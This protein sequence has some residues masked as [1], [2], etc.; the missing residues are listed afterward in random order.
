MIRCDLWV[1]ISYLPAIQLEISTTTTKK[2]NLINWFKEFVL[3]VNIFNNSLNNQIR[4][5]HNT[6]QIRWAIQSLQNAFN[7]FIL[8]IA[9]IFEL[10]FRNAVQTIFNASLGSF[11]QLIVHFNDGHIIAGCCRNLNRNVC[12]LFW[13]NDCKNWTMNSV[14]TMTWHNHIIGCC[15]PLQK[16]HREIAK[17]Q[18]RKNTILNLLEQF[19]NP[20]NRHQ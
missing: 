5:F 19:Q 4:L 10:L 18:N 8:L 20:S 3:D 2:I 6:S 9:I 17:L 13:S 12:D 14:L 15:E 16:S 11:N 1:T 7:E